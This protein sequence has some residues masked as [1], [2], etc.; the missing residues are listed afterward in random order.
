MSLPKSVWNNIKEITKWDDNDVYINQVLKQYPNI[1]EHRD[2]N[3][4]PLFFFIVHFLSNYK[5][6]LTH[7]K[8]DPSIVNSRGDTVLFDYYSMTSE[9]IEFLVNYGVHVNVYNKLNHSAVYYNDN[10]GVVRTLLE[11][12]ANIDEAKLCLPFWEIYAKRENVCRKASIIL[13]G[14][15]K[16]R[17]TGLHKDVAQV[18]AKMIWAKRRK[19]IWD[20]TDSSAKKLKK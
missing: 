5:Y 19:S 6:F 1:N 9:K 8:W 15:G 12:G 14:I 20:M 16:R 17:R 2:E 3:G 11:Y 13:L 7:Y 10:L 4:V 18:I